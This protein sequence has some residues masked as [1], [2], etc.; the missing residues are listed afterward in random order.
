VPDRLNIAVQHHQSGRLDVAEALYREILSIQ[1]SNP[2]ALHLLGVLTHQRGHHDEAVE[3]IERAIAANPSGAAAYRGNLAAALRALGRFGEAVVA[4]RAAAAA[5]PR[6]PQAHNNL[7][8]ALKDAGQFNDAATAYRRAIV[9]KPDYAE[10]HYNLGIVLVELGQTSD[11]IA[12]YRQALAHR[13]D[14][15]KAANNL[16]EALRISRRLDE[17]LEAFRRAIAIAP[18]HAAAH[19][20]LGIVLGDT[21][22]LDAAVAAC[23]RAL[24]IK[25][26]FAEAHSNL[27]L[28]MHYHP[29]FDSAQILDES[30][31]WNERHGSKT[32]SDERGTM[33]GATV[34]RSSFIG[35]RLRIG[36]ISP[37][38]RDHVVGRNIL[39]LLREH[40][41]EHFEIFCYASVRR[42]DAIT[43]EFR[44]YADHWRDIRRASDDDAA[45]IIREDHLDILVDLALHTTGNRLLVMA[46][47]PSPIQACFA[48]YPG[49]TG[50]RAMDY[51]M[52]DP[53]LDPP[54]QTEGDY[55]EKTVRLP[56]CFWCY[57]PVAM[58]CEID[59]G[60]LPALSNGYITF[61]CLN[62]F[63]KV[64][65]QTLALWAA[66]MQAVPNA[67]LLLHV[68]AVESPRQS[69]LSILKGHGI[70]S[71]RLEFVDPQ[72]RTD[73]FQT[74]RRIDIALDTLPY[75]GHTTSL[76]A[77][78][79]GVPVLTL[80]GRTVV[81]RAGVSQLTNLG[82]IDWIARAPEQFAN[83]AVTAAGDLQALAELR[84]GLR[85]RMR[86]SPLCDAAR[87]ARNIEAVYRSM[88]P[89][90]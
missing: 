14:M 53:H 49:G 18:Q 36:Y 6:D 33:N 22:E 74:Y 89:S 2:D 60:P 28:A 61:G 86:G 21:G 10:A 43:A 20:N 34:H 15:A 46:R 71:S 1:P 88:Q 66:A 77:L 23:R 59:P 27:V 37:D 5:S 31:R 29:A 16:G 12:S 87:F 78:W 42:A 44:S 38:F 32:M 84:A 63:R 57:D 45:A 54:G 3:L 55:V 47:K 13:P 67:R 51:R 76:D 9:L 85:E 70:D 4:C 69:T 72:P 50:L 82:M 65:A 8:V 48:G 64:S 81:G 62:N 40:D 56:N 19:N 79:M 52:S 26:D 11:A 80:A 24:A 75:N 30:K 7:G 35:H 68:P 90:V 58:D 41:H 25:P 83:R 39:P 17:A 73:Y